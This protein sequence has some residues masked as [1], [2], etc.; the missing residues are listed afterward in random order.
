MITKALSIRA[1]WWWYIVH[2]YKD[3][4]NRDW[5][6]SFRGPVWIH[7]G[8]WWSGNGVQEDIREIQRTLMEPGITVPPRLSDL[9][10]WAGSIVGSAEVV[11]CVRRH[12]SRWFQGRYGFVLRNAQPLE[13]PVPLKGQL[14]F[15]NVPAGLMGDAL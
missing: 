13:A 9:Q 14:G 3:I 11:D 8:K 10:P 6:T 15:F 1:P 12:N 5:E 7:A 4:E 2:G